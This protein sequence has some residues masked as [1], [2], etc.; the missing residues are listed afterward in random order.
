[1]TD[2]SKLAFD[3]RQNYMKRS[4]FTGSADL[5]LG[6][7]NEVTTYTV[8]HDL[9]FVPFFIVGAEQN[10]SSTI[11]SGNRVHEYTKTGGFSANVPVELEYWCDETDLTIRIVNGRG[12]GSQAGQTRTVYWIIYLDYGSS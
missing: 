1:M 12:T 10:D 9:G 5:V 11:W 3:S 4:E 7:D 2:L 6:T 8:T